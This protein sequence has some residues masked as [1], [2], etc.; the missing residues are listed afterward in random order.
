MTMPPFEDCPPENARLTSY[1]ELHLVTYLR[2]LDADKEG[3]DW[4]EAVQ[5][6]FGLDAE[7]EPGARANCLHQPSRA[8]TL[9][10]QGWLPALVGTANAV[11]TPRG[12]SHA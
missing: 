8:G 4:R 11:I 1:D 5:I 3:A 7:K 2:L 6:I 10:D 12:T 9:D